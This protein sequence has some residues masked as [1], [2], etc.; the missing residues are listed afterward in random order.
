M[1]WIIPA[2]ILCADTFNDIRHKEIYLYLTAA[3]TASGLVYDLVSAEAGFTGLIVSLLPGML[4]LAVSAVSRGQI[5]CGDSLVLLMTGT[6]AGPDI[7]IIFMT[8]L[9]FAAIFAGS[10]W[11]KKRQNSEFPFVPFILA[12]FAADTIL[13]KTALLK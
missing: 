2:L 9:F 13:M 5:G 1:S 4:F 11:I 10:L 3:G 7:W 8:A 6:W 12:G